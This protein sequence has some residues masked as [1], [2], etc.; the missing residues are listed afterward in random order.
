M[1]LASKEKVEALG[2]KPIAKLTSTADAAQAPEWFT[3]A[4]S[5][6]VP[7]ALKKAN[8]D[9]S[10][11]DFFELN[12]AFS[13]VALANNKEMGLPADKVNVHGGAVFS[14]SPTR[15]FR[16]AYRSYPYSVYL[17]KTME[18]M[19][20]PVFVTVVAVLLQL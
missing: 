5:K 12:E 16:S 10:D 17:I 19:V 1:V 8:L 9:Y 13:V 4:P 2:L 20:L 15:M 6:A 18:N 7:K 11:I 14:W 3:T